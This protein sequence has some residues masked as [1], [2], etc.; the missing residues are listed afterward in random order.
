MILWVSAA[1]IDV[2]D[3]VSAWVCAFVALTGWGKVL[4]RFVRSL[5]A[6]RAAAHF[7]RCAFID[8]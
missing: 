1:M 4:V 6:M 8:K 5:R 7:R 2:L 3:G